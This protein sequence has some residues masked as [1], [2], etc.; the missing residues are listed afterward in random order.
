[1]TISRTRHFIGDLFAFALIVAP[2]GVGMS[3][4]PASATTGHALRPALAVAPRTFPPSAVTFNVTTTAD[5]HDATPS[6]PTCAD[7]SGQ[8]SLR[9]ALEEANASGKTTTIN[10]T[11]TNYPLTIGVLSATDPQ[12]VQIVGAGSSATSVTAKATVG[13]LTLAHGAS[14][15]G[16]FVSLTNLTVKG[17]S[18]AGNGGGINV[19]DSND[20]LELTGA[21]I[22]GNTA[23]NGG[24]VYNEGELWATNSSFTGNTST[25]S[26]SVATTGGGAIYN[27][28]GSA[29]LTNDSFSG[30]SA[31]TGGGAIHNFNGPASID[32][33][34][35]TSNTV[36]DA[37]SAAGGAVYADDATELTNDTFTNNTATA[38]GTN[39]AV[40]GAVYGAY[41]LDRV[42]GSTFNGNQSIS[43]SAQ[44]GSAGAFYDGNAV[45]ISQSTFT[46]NTAVN[47]VG[48]AIDEESDGLILNGDT[49]S[50]NF[51]TGTGGNGLG[52]ALYGNNIAN[53][54][55]STFDGNHADAAG[56]GIATFDGMIMNNSTVSRN[57]STLGAGIDV[58]WILQ[59]TSD[60][61]VD[62]TASG[63]ANAGGGIYLTPSVSGSNAVH[64]DL[65]SD[66]IAGNVSDT[67]A[68]IALGGGVNLSGGGG[69]S[70]NTIAGN[71]TSAGAEQDCGFAGTPTSYPLGS[72]GG[73]V[74]GDATCAFATGSDRQG[75][76]A[77]GYW[78]VASD[79]GMFTFNGGFFGSMGGKPLNKPIVGLA[80]TPGN[81]G[82]WEVASDGGIFTFGDASFLGSMG[83][84][85]LNAPVVGMAAT[86]DGR[87][88]LQ[89]ASDGG[90]FTFGSA[91][92]Y[93]S[94]GGQHLN[95]PIVGIA[96]TPD[97]R[98]YWEAASDGGI[99]AFGDAGY[100]GS[101]GGTVLNKP[102]VGIA[103]A[104]DG[105]GYYE[106]ASDGGIFTFG[107]A[108]FA[109]STGAI[110]LNAPMVGLAVS[111]DNH[112]YSEFA[113][114]GGVFTWGSSLFH[115][116]AGGTRLNQP[117]VGG[118]GT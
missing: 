9:A 8:C 74:V 112:G 88:Y 82:Y 100:F 86:P 35:F 30:N 51:A 62:N 12:G 101:M 46:G 79:G 49:L 48:G 116:S 61:F 50:A 89:V 57:T 27:D 64:V 93:G 41:G 108:K 60:A 23:A 73:N 59:A 84:K 28:Y 70:N 18:M 43:P 63:P 65:Q 4:V 13:V 32:S 72:A 40:G 38:T 34:S 26:G 52:G 19:A 7:S 81:Q 102:V 95:K 11:A 96:V 71:W 31:V 83:G 114:D 33:S 25:G 20:T 105:L 56:G 55:D 21:T 39:S 109:G 80:H 94:M 1:M 29:R 2:L 5:T 15:A 77:Q 118:A 3:A 76:S 87:G 42:I 66:T 16:A 53:V 14:N 6:N 110:H 68:G 36:N 113:S 92:F 111:P 99:F 117:V 10:L 90:I 37:G 44:G 98:G 75:A 115:G 45:T 47:G 91:K 104:T 58:G 103:P 24:G 22:A 17:A 85:P 54:N 107:T 67:G 106:V 69:L 78:E 97:G